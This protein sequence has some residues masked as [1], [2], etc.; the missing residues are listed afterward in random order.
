MI[1]C[2]LGPKPKTRITDQS[3]C[4]NVDRGGAADGVMMH[5]ALGDIGQEAQAQ[6]PLKNHGTHA[7]HGVA[8]DGAPL[9]NDVSDLGQRPQ[10]RL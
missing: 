3:C 9:H 10:D 6:L 8:D 4:T 2:L 7:D 1:S 5:S